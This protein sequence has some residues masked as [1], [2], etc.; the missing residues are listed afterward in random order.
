MTDEIKIVEQIIKNVVMKF[1]SLYITD[2]NQNFDLNKIKEYMYLKFCLNDKILSKKEYVL[3]LFRIVEHLNLELSTN[4]VLFNIYNDSNDMIY[5]H[6][7]ISLKYYK[8]FNNFNSNEYFFNIVIPYNHNDI[9]IKDFREYMN[10]YNETTE[11]DKYIDLLI[12]T[13]KLTYQIDGIYKIEYGFD[14]ISMI[15]D[16]TYSDDESEDEDESDDNSEILENLSYVNILF[17]LFLINQCKSKYVFSNISLHLIDTI[18]NNNNNDSHRNKLLFYK[19]N[20]NNN[21]KIDVYHY[22]PHGLNDGFSFNEMNIKIIFNTL[23]TIIKSLILKKYKNITEINF[24]TDIISSKKGSQIRYNEDNGYCTVY[25]TFWYNIVL[26][27][28]DNIQKHDDKKISIITVDKW[29][30]LVDDEIIN[31]RKNFL[32]TYDNDKYYNIDELIELNNYVFVEDFK[33]NY[34]LFNNIE[35]ENEF[36]NIIKNKIIKLNENLNESKKINIKT[37]YDYY[38][39]ILEEF[40]VNIKSN[41]HKLKK[42]EYFIM[43]VNYAYSIYELSYSNNIYNNK[44]FIKLNEFILNSKVIKGL[45]C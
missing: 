2:K 45:N 36:Y 24:D 17:L 41:Q 37:M 32:K 18:G 34:K 19:N 14:L 4:K 6:L 38:D 27:I 31:I 33:D 16:C 5:S 11:T 22:E 15:N 13:S 44:E 7:N 42:L 30:H 23:N 1:A 40:N 21:T 12:K 35:N 28:I 3:N 10:K 9:I 26:E 43:I 20:E 29:I 8:C 25:S 39:N